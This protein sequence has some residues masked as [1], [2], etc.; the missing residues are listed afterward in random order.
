MNGP[1]LRFRDDDG[2]EFPAW[3]ESTIGERANEK[4]LKFNPEKSTEVFKCIELEH[5]SQ[6]TGEML[7]YTST[8]TSKSIKN[9]FQEGD[10]L[11][12]KLRPYLRKFLKAPFDGVCSTEIW[13]LKGK[14][15]INEFL[16]QFVQTENFVTQANISSGSKMPRADWGIVSSATSFFPSLPEQ[17]KIANFLTAVDEKITQLTQKSD[18]LSQYKKGVMQKIFSQELRFKDGDGREFPEWKEVLLGDVA[19]FMKGKGISKADID[20]EGITPCIRYGELYTEYG[21][22]IC[23]VKSKT[24]IDIKNLVLSE[25]NDVIIPAS[26]ETQIDIATASCVQLSGVALGGDL[27]IIKSQENGVFL[28]Y[29]LNNQKKLDIAKLAQ[30]NSVVHLYSSQL[31]QLNIKLPIKSEQTKIADFLT[32]IDYKVTQTQAELDAVKQYKQG[33]LQQMFI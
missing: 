9:R 16:F 11:F 12:G 4:S 6:N 30:G 13:V 17:T 33:L 29:Y 21:E 20:D 5:I 19:S 26:G 22:I 18:L 8:E 2:Q 10:V 15:V 31:K 7:G 27:N 24:N 14:G 1:K 32:A 3:E 25:A 28:S 23:E